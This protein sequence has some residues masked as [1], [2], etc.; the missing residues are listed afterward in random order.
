MRKLLSSLVLVAVVVSASACKD[1]LAQ[2]KQDGIACARDKSTLLLQKDT[3][4][5]H[6]FVC[7]D[8]D[9]MMKCANDP[10]TSGCTESPCI[11]R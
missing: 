6:C 3:P 7:N 4:N 1:K 2:M 11:K 10:L 5:Q 9:S 8:N